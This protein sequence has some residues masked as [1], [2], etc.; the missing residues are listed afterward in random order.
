MVR[1]CPTRELIHI[2]FEYWYKSDSV[3][4]TRARVL[5]TCPK[6]TC[7]QPGCRRFTDEAVSRKRYG[8]TMLRSI[9][10]RIMNMV[11][12]VSQTYQRFHS[13]AQSTL[14]ISQSALPSLR[15]TGTCRCLPRNSPCIDA[16]RYLA[17]SICRQ[18]SGYPPR[19]K[20]ASRRAR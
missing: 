14:T 8:F 3:V 19:Y 20:L 17:I 13:R 11:A 6:G 1:R 5:R 4:R 2:I 9:D 16:T 12:M 18:E 10:R 15:S 7:S